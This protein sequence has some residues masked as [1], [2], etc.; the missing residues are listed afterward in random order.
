MTLDHCEK[1]GRF[2]IKRNN[3]V[4]QSDSGSQVFSV[5]Y[6]FHKRMQNL[7][8]PHPLVKSYLQHLCD[9]CEILKKKKKT[10][11]KTNTYTHKQILVSL[12]VK[13]YDNIGYTISIIAF[14]SLQ[15]A[16]IYCIF[17]RTRLHPT[18]LCKCWFCTVLSIFL[19]SL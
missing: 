12:G 8:T 13:C 4:K 18:I 7:S 9:V 17:R 14:F 15:L 11:K 2:E 1:M 6:K 5:V 16:G 3:L 10:F 19:P